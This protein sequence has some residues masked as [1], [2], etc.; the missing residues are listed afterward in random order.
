MNGKDDG[1]GGSMLQLFVATM[2]MGIVLS[3]TSWVFQEG[4]NI[5]AADP[6][7][8]AEISIGR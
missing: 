4:H 7:G 6:S 1:A 3:V 2:V 8:T 5:N